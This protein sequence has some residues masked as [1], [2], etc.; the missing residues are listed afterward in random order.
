ML[1]T[2]PFTSVIINLE[3]GLVTLTESFSPL[4]S[5]LHN[6]SLLKSKAELRAKLRN[7]LLYHIH[8]NQFSLARS[9]LSQ[10]QPLPL[11][12]LRSAKALWNFPLRHTLFTD[13]DDI[14]LEMQIQIFLENHNELLM[15][16]C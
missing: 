4:E 11:T 1:D 7:S 10:P 6:P 5:E 2:I 15:T 14:F 9:G 8:Y 3:Y 12:R 13:T 16:Y